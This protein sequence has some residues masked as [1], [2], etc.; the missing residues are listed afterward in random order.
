VRSYRWA[1]VDLGSFRLPANPPG[2]DLTGLLAEVEKDAGLRESLIP[3]G[4]IKFG[5]GP[6]VDDDPVCFDIKS[7]TQR[8]DYRIVKVDHEEIL[9]H[10]RVKVVAEVAPSFEHLV[11]QVIERA[12]SIGG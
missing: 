9:C 12:E 6:D 1:E 7:Q 5:M 10:H 4:F 2:S 3:A 8:Q 11:L